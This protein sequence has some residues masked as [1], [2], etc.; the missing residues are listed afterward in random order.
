MNGS[1]GETCPLAVPVTLLLTFGRMH[2][3]DDDTGSQTKAAGAGQTLAAGPAEDLATGR[4]MTIDTPDGNQIAIYNV[5]GELF[6]TENFCPHQGSP[7]SEGFLCGH[8]IE[9]G[10][11]GWEFDVRSGECLTL[12]ETIKIF[13]VTVEDGVIKVTV[14]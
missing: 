10:L 13:P 12:T 11:H 5:N 2:S 4:V 6:A 7:L 9:C 3:V 14:E 8:V 1:D